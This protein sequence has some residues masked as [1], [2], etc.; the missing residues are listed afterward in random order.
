MG[1]AGESVLLRRIKGIRAVS[2]CSCCSISRA[3]FSAYV[4]LA[5]GKVAPLASAYAPCARFAPCLAGNFVIVS[6]RPVNTLAVEES[7]KGAKALIYKVAAFSSLFIA[8]TASFII[9]SLR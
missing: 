1:R 4:R 7:I 6:G 8:K 3:R 9:A 2:G 5:S